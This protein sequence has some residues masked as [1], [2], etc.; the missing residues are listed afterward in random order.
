M[1]IIST[2]SSLAR[3][4]CCINESR[5]PILALFGPDNFALLV[6][7]NIWMAQSASVIFSRL[8]PLSLRLTFTNSHERQKSFCLFRELALKMLSRKAQ[9]ICGPLCKI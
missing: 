5:F 1:L 6:R 2:G 3:V 8:S 9:Y 7:T 4:V